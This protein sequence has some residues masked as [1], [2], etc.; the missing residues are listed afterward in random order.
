MAS[1]FVNENLTKGRKDLFTRSNKIRKKNGYQYIWTYN[2]KTNV[3][4]NTSSAKFDNRNEKDII[5]IA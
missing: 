4:K 3:K 5:K 1:L 2:G